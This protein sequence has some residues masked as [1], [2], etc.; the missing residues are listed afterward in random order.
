MMRF[1]KLRLARQL[2]PGAATVLTLTVAVTLRVEHSCSEEAR[3]N[4]QS[5]PSLLYPYP[6]IL[7]T[8]DSLSLMGEALLLKRFATVA[9]ASQE[10][11]LGGDHK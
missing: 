5:I 6:E 7:S 11:R 10:H 9:R 8:K 2:L 1:P 4:T 3:P